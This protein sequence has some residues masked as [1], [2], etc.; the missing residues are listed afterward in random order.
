M[1]EMKRN[2][3]ALTKWTE[4]KWKQSFRNGASTVDTSFTRE[5]S[6]NIRKMEL[7]LFVTTLFIPLI[8]SNDEVTTQKSLLNWYETLPAVA[9]DY[10]VHI[11]AGL[12]GDKLMFTRIYADITF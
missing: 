10:K 6:D 2:E 3:S 4:T 9:M 12:F 5:D 8:S 1:S 11:D 7:L